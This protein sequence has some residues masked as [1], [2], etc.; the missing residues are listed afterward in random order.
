MS[1]P[2]IISIFEENFHLLPNIR[3]A[4][5]HLCAISLSFPLTAGITPFENGTPEKHSI[6]SVEWEFKESMLPG[7]KIFYGPQRQLH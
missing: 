6:R 3:E 1:V 4:E 2:F 5:S 7:G